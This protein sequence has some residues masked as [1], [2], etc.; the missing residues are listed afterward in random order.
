M[1]AVAVDVAVADGVAESV[2]RDDVDTAGVAVAEPHAVAVAE[3][4]DDA[5]TLAESVARRVAVTHALGSH[6]VCGRHFKPQ[7]PRHHG[8]NCVRVRGLLGSS[9]P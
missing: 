5:L 3:A 9:M 6:R 7:D 2:V 8:G 4:E 1:D